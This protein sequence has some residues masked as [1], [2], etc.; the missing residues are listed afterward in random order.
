M[1]PLIVVRDVETAP[2]QYLTYMLNAGSHGSHA[3]RHQL[4]FVSITVHLQEVTFAGLG[5]V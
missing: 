2:E 5:G 4:E 3:A 1:Y